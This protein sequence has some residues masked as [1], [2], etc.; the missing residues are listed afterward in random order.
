MPEIPIVSNLSELLVADGDD[1][2]A[3]AHLH[4][5]IEHA[6]L[7]R[8][9]SSATAKR[10]LTPNEKKRVRTV[11]RN[12]LEACEGSERII[13][14]SQ[15]RPMTH[16]GVP[17]RKGFTADCSGL[18]TGAF[19]RAR[20]ITALPVQD[21]NGLGFSG[22]GYTGT[23]L[24]ANASRSVRPLKDR[25]FFIGDIVIYGTPTHTKHTAIC[26][27]GGRL[28]WSV[29]TSHGSEAGPIPVRL[30]YRPDIVGVYRPWSLR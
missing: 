12:Y 26:R 6:E 5:H 23:L 27:K 16:L 29:W 2:A 14:Y 28:E 1:S 18:V 20:E 15:H 24:A 13:H 30:D 17:A 3:L 19:Y 11:I 25:V 10:P 4:A 22:W 7:E 21:P 8:T 9:L